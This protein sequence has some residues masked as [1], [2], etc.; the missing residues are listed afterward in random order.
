MNIKEYIFTVGRNAKQASRQLAQLD[1]NAKNKILLAMADGLN[2]HRENIKGQNA[3]DLTDGKKNGLT[4]SLLDRLELNDS[5]IDA[6]I[7]SIREIVELNDP[8]GKIISTVERPNGLI[9]E[10]V[11]SPIGVVGIIYESRP[12]VSS[13][14]A[15]LCLKSSNAVILRGGSEAL[16]SN[17]AIV[18]ALVEGGKSAGMPEHAI[19]LVD[20]P[21]REAV[22]ELAQM[23]DYLDL[24]IPRGGEGLIRAIAEMARVPVIKHY[25]GVCHVYVDKAADLNMALDICVN[26]KCQRPGVCNAAETVLVSKDIAAEFLPKLSE[27]LLAAGVELRGDDESKKIVP[28]MKLATE[29]DW[30]T[31]Y[32]E[33]ILSI[34]VVDNVEKA[35]EHINY[36]GSQHSDSI[37]TADKAAA[38]KFLKEVDSAAVY[39][40]ASTRFTD[41]AVFGL[42]A[43]MG[44]S[45][46]KIH[47]RGPMG[48]EELCTYKFVVR[49]SG[50]IR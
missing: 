5:R 35:I 2:T 6:M 13:D 3:L 32:L 31:E 49:G 15:S 38:E 30:H 17:R 22:K 21:D 41:G 8:V 47:A 29:E 27:K 39:V 28:S 16:R 10:K 7:Q 26:A 45:T 50:Q 18:E 1:T 43:E 11:K 34:K 20:T 42:G 40:N 9:I 36:Y 33:L 14:A 25:K 37:V 44:I 48:I 19:Q 12:N 4:S 23:T 24:I 46:D